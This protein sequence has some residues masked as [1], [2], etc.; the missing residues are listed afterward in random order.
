MEITTNIL[1]ALVEKAKQSPLIGDYEEM[2][3]DEHLYLRYLWALAREFKPKLIIEYG[4][5]K[6]LSALHLAEGNPEGKV[7]SIDDLSLA[8]QILLEK[9]ICVLMLLILYKIV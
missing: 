4:T 3:P 1:L 9:I 2:K 8:K 6:G 5:W 7:I